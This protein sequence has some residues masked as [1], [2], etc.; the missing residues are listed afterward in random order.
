MRF[1]ICLLAILFSIAGQNSY[2][3]KSSGKEPIS[4][5][6]FGGTSKVNPK[7][8]NTELQSRSI[9]E[10]K[11]FVDLGAEGTFGASGFLS[12]GLRYVHRIGI[13]SEVVETPLTS[14][15]ATLRQDT[16]V[17][18]A[19]YKLMGEDFYRFDIMLGLGGST[20][21]VDVSSVSGSGEWSG[22]IFTGS[23]YALG[24]ASFAIGY[25]SFFIFAEYGYAYNKLAAIKREGN[26]TANVG[27]IDLSGTYGVVGIMFDAD[28]FKGLIKK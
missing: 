2:A 16:L 5:R 4:I 14:Y 8:L 26:A 11:S 7:E 6:L 13:M 27:S 10:A 23:P 9:E 15:S 1:Q 17:G 12:W 28:I 21:R 24:G 20:T 22:D 18:I 19:R 3:A 25:K